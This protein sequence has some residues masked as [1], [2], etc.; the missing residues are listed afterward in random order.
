M[1]TSAYACRLPSLRSTASCKQAAAGQGHSGLH[2]LR[3]CRAHS[4]RS[5]VRCKQQSR[6]ALRH[7]AAALRR[8]RCAVHPPAG[9]LATSLVP[10]CRSHSLHKPQPTAAPLPQR[11]AP[12]CG[13][14]AH[15]QRISVERFGH[16]VAA[17][18]LLHTWPLV[19][20]GH[21]HDNSG[22]G[23][24]LSSADRLAATGWAGACRSLRWCAER[25]PG[26]AAACTRATLCIAS[27]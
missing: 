10:C 17:Q 25:G 24:H 27:P 18:P 8:T 26:H 20:W 3:A 16:S 11:R 22:R 21:L 15:L 9:K 2:R 6:R 7:R 13:A 23:S 4:L 5:T 12:A 14:E 19:P 1:S